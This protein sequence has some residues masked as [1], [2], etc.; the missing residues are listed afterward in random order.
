MKTEDIIQFN[1]FLIYN[2]V[3]KNKFEIIYEYLILN[4]CKFT[5]FFI[6]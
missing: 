4:N 6:V 2:I 5:H 3:L 1:I